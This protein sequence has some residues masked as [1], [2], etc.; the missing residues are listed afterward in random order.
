MT[1]GTK[2]SRRIAVDGVSYRWRIRRKPTYCQAMGWSAFTFAVGLAE[3]T[4]ST[5]VVT[6]PF[7]HPSN[8]MQLPSGPVTPATVEASIRHALADGWR[9]N[10]P[11][12][13]HI[14]SEWV[15][16]D[17]AITPDPDRG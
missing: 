15:C 6:M 5:L 14:L 8:W 7:A 12:L 11:G 16:R 10:R 2:G 3:A 9:P 4:G 13:P 1:L 17:T